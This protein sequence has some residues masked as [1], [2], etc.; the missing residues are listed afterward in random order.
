MSIKPWKVL[1]RKRDKSYRIFNLRTDRACSPR[2]GR[3]HDFFILESSP[4]VNII[5]LTDKNEVVMVRQYRHGIQDIT[6]EIPGGIIEGEET[7]ED[8]AIRELCEETGYRTT[9]ELISLGMV[10]PN[11][12]IQ[13][14]I[15]Y[16]FLAKGAYL[17]G[18]Q[19]LDEM[20]DIETI[21][22]PLSDI[23]RFIREG[24][25]SHSLVLVAF[26]R[27]FIEYEMKMGHVDPH[28][29]NRGTIGGD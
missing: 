4:W 20:E 13:Q 19:H 3:A 10:Y 11:P 15:C 23:P 9:S 18:K 24:D 12:A 5:P 2:T 27:L 26:Y 14:N 7:P 22:L 25:I 17:A 29:P 28:L 6:L 8:T 21:L 1:S 16:S